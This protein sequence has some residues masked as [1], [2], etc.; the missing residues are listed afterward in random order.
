MLL[1]RGGEGAWMSLARLA[2]ALAEA[3]RRNRVCVKRSYSSESPSL[4]ACKD[5][6]QNRSGRFFLGD[7]VMSVRLRNILNGFRRFDVGS[8]SLKINKTQPTLV[9]IESNQFGVAA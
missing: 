4:S 2:F 5:V 3:E 9:Q 1:T 6:S 8:R 7:K